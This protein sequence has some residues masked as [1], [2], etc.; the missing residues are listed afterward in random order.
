VS[1]TQSSFEGWAIV[2]IMGHNKEIGYVT[3]QYFG[4]VGLF[5]VDQPELPERE[6]ELKS[7]QY[8]GHKWTPAGAKVKRSS[9]P[10]KTALVGPSSIFRITPCTELLAV[11]AI[12]NMLAPPLIL[13][14]M[15]ERVQIG[16]GADH[17]DDFSQDGE[18]DER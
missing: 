16:N 6:Y 18:D 13:L 8:V 3:T 15:P 5:R 11:E 17:D 4:P 1:E 7:P 2:E 9:L 12:E 10:A 14:S